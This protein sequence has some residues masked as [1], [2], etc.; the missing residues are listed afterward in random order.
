MSK[1]FVLIAVVLLLPS[2]GFSSILKADPVDCSNL[3]SHDKVVNPK[4]NIAVVLAPTDS[5]IDMESALDSVKS[6][7]KPSLLSNDDSTRMTVVVADG[8]PKVVGSSSIDLKKTVDSSQDNSLVSR[9]IGNLK[10]VIKC[11]N[12]TSGDG[13]IVVRDQPDFLAAIVE[14]H[15]AIQENSESG[16]IFVVGNGLQTGGSLKLQNS[17]PG[18]DNDISTIVG[19]LEDS[20]VIDGTTLAGANIT[21]LGLGQVAG[22]AQSPLNLQSKK[23][24]AKLW[25]EILSASGATINGD[26]LIPGTLPF[27]K[28]TSS[29]L[30]KSTKVKALADSCTI[31]LSE[32]EIS[33]NPG[34][35]TF[36]APVKARSAAVA[37][38]VKLENCNRDLKVTGYVASDTT[39]EEFE[40]DPNA[41]Q[42]LSFK[43]AQAVKKLLHSVGVKNR[44]NSIG[45]G[46]KLPDWDAQGNPDPVKQAL[47][48]I[49]EISPA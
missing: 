48:R 27:S 11:V 36:K 4:D 2:C 42:A 25:T 41:G 6:M 38:K 43:R 49:V 1:L 28:N 14:A 31:T 44:I 5:F 10:S 12:Q 7:L 46:H 20:G 30:I 33:F 39:K 40:K 3:S 13:R 32:N 24:L 23:L 9:S 21:W 37:V 19:Q 18:S 17:F 35:A 34:L 47:N 29:G 16:T 45:G 8:A 22:Q 26:K 15:H